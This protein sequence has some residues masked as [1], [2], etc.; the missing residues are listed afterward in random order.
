MAIE[1]R[2]RDLK[3]VRER[4]GFSVSLRPLQ[5][6][7]TEEQYLALTDHTRR[8]IELTDGV[9][10]PLAPATDRHQVLV[11]FLYDLLRA[12]VSQLG[13]KVLV[14]P[15][16]LQVREGKQREPDIL[17]VRDAS[18]PRRQ[19]RFSLGADL[20]V[21]VVSPDDPER[22][23]VEKVADYAEAGIPEYWIVNP[24]DETVTVL[25]LQG[26][27]YAT[28][29]VFRRGDVATSVLLAGFTA[30]VSDILDAS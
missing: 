20:V 10:E 19:N 18:D 16:R 28:H 26:E 6:L 23:T 4:D 27:A 30:D 7:W 9:L 5:G 2:G 14:A 11:L 24:E 29:G 15:L 22:D 3:L 12:F 1:M 13:G 25:S 17:L 21:E 8:L